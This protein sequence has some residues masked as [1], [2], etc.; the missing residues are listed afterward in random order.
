M[1]NYSYG[2][3]DE[4]LAKREQL[5]GLTKQSRIQG[6]YHEALIKEWFLRFIDDKLSVKNG[7]IINGKQERSGE[8]DIIIFNNEKK[9]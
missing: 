5:R 6:D 8:C 1:D 7:L 3:R 9:P 2:L 4:L